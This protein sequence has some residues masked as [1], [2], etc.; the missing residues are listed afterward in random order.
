MKRNSI[1]PKYLFKKIGKVRWTR[2]DAFAVKT[3]R[4]AVFLLSPNCDE[5]VPT[6]V[7]I[8]EIKVPESLRRRGVATEALAALCQLADE[9]QFELEGGPIGFNETLWRDKFVEWVL[10]F[11]FVPDPDPFLSIFDDPNV[12]CVCRPPREIKQRH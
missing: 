4:G 5:G 1:S 9:Y 10:R 11:G 3:D 6:T 12:F 8:D 2:F 7:H